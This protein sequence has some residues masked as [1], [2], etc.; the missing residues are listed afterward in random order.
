MRKGC[1]KS[2]SYPQRICEY[3]GALNGLL[4][5]KA[6]CL[7]SDDKGTVYIGTDCGLNFT[8]ADGSFG[9]F[10]CGNVNVIHIMGNKIWFAA[11]K[12]VYLFE[13]GKIS[14]IQTFD[15]E[16]K[17][18]SGEKEAFLI[19]SYTLYRFIDGEFTT[20]HGTELPSGGLEINDGK[21][22][23]F[24]GRS[25]CIFAG[26]RKHWMCI[27]PEHSTMPE[28]NINCVAFDKS[29]GFIW[30]GTDKGAYIY[31]N[32]NGWYGHKEIDC[33]PEEEI[34]SI[35]L[36]DDG[37]VI[38]STDAGLAIINNGT[39]KYL[40][41]TRWTCAEKVNDAIAVGSD[42]WTATDEGVTKISEK[43]MTLKE[44]ADYCFDY[45]EK[46]YIR[47]DGYLTGIKG[48][49]NHD[50]STGTPAITDNDGLWTHTYLGSL[51]YN[52]AVTK[53]EKVLEAARRSMYAM[54]KLCKVSGIKGFTARAIR[55]EGEEGFGTIV[56]RDGHEWHPSPDGTC[57]W[58]GETS[59]DEMTGH[60]FGFSLYYEFCANEEEKAVIRE[61]V[62]DMVDH[63]IEHDYRL[64]DIDGLPTTWAVWTPSELNGNSMWLWEKGVN[65]LEMLTF[66]DVA[67]QV[68]GDE[69]YR[70]E[71]MRLA[72]DE[73][74]II[75]SAQHKKHDG[76]VTH[77]DDNLGFMC[78]ST[79]LRIEKDP[80]IRKYLLMGLKHHWDYERIENNATFNL[81]YGA[82]TDEVCDIDTAIKGLRDLPLDFVQRKMINSNRRNLVYDTEQERWG[83]ERQLKIP[84][85]A[86]QKIAYHCDRNPFRVDTGRPE[87]ASSPSTYLL[88][89]WIGR[90]YGLIEEE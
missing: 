62:C 15:E 81:I 30:L 63:M 53:D 79:I 46:Y 24:S 8:K 68:S 45:A 2:K 12:I 26:K 41:A 71:F 33:L 38:L 6:N 52:Y 11:D 43:M 51:C 75:N 49:V 74:F 28:F 39:T 7:A 83:G 65:S 48:I 27:F 78:T 55:Y 4:S 67:Y 72:I 22:I 44:K 57:E 5:D 60:F 80:A 86:D 66:L 17:G 87:R 88:P 20:Y 47:T 18:I 19:T 84:L 32:R 31:D 58:L 59:S 76:H 23:S 37:K 69:K 21:L 56:E 90:Y 61:V 77:I 89:Y 34:L 14:E 25:L 64:C 54:V 50:I 85:D 13:D 10:P 16:I 35:D 82:F 1:Y 73:H 40:P 29:L 9:S 36:T 42:I 3:Y 70:E